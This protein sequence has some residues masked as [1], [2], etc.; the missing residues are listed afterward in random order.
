MTF[1]TPPAGESEFLQ[2]KNMFFFFTPP[3]LIV[4]LYKIIILLLIKIK[5]RISVKD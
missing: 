3:A 4:I 5:Y 1:F 2:Y